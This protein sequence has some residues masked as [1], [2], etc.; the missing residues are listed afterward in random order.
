MHNISHLDPEDVTSNRINDNF[1]E[2]IKQLSLLN[3]TI[4]K[5][6]VLDTYSRKEIDDLINK[7]SIDN[8]SAITVDTTDYIVERGAIDGATDP[9]I[10]ERS[11][12]TDDI[13]ES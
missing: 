2:I 13:V 8:S 9:D 3:S 10:E 1:A 5:I 6:Q 7:V 4:K 12:N 11:I